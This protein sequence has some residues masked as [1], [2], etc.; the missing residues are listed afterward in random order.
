MREQA[1]HKTWALLMCTVA[2]CGSETADSEPTPHLLA[3]SPSHACALRSA[4]LYCW[5]DN[6]LGQLGNGE[7]TESSSAVAAD[8]E[9]K[10]I[11]EVAA[12]SARTCIRTRSGTVACWG[13][14]DVG[15]IGDGTRSDA[16]TAV[17]A[18]GIDD[19]IAFAIDEESTCVVHAHGHTVSCWG[20]GRQ[21]AWL[22]RRIEGLANVRELRAGA[23]GHY[24]A[25]D[26]SDAVWCWSSNSGEWAAATK[27]DALAGAHAIAV[28][29]YNTTCALVDAGNIVCHNVDSGRSVA[30]GDS[31][32]V[33]SMNAAGGLVLCANKSD[34]RWYCWNVLPQMLETVG[35][36]SI[37]VPSSVPLT[38]L[39]I[40][41][42]RA[43]ALRQ[44]E[45]VVCAD[46]N[47]LLIGLD[48]VDPAGLKTVDGLPR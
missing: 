41:G 4:G 39:V 27:V 13:S 10:D 32:G 3:V 5:G 6:F 9:R 47:E 1:R 30:L 22:P 44:D 31:D 35:S 24:C 33:L 25:R 43:C 29:T 23:T 42:F 36:P 38:D 2:A 46:A 21:E 45:Q 26:A 18:K 40:S 37:A 28:P 16:L 8:V 20:G 11:V 14:N 15:Q 48:G 19:A 7:L 17:A 34:G 12:A